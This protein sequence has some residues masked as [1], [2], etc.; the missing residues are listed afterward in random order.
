MDWYLY[1]AK[2]FQS[3]VHRLRSSAYVPGFTVIPDQTYALLKEA[4]QI[5]A[6]EL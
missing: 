1:P 2:A 6:E 4:E 3:Y 5:V